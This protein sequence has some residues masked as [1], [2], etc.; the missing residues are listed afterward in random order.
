LDSPQ[1]TNPAEPSA[2]Q[3]GYGIERQSFSPNVTMHY[4]FGELPGFNSFA[5]YDPGNKVTLVLW[6]NLTVSP[7]SRPTANAL[8]LKVVEQ[9][10][11]LP[12]QAPPSAPTTTR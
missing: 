7:D 6:S 2:P 9:I 10:Y 1:P 4:H 8:L 11:T 12:A 3:Y 5:G